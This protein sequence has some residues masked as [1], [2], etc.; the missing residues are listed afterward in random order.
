[1][2]SQYFPLDVPEPGLEMWATAYN[3]DQAYTTQSQPFQFGCHEEVGND[4]LFN[5]TPVLAPPAQWWYPE[6]GGA[7][8]DGVYSNSLCSHKPPANW[9][10]IVR[11]RL[12][13]RRRPYAFWVVLL[14]RLRLSVHRLAQ[15][16]SSR[17]RYDVHGNGGCHVYGRTIGGA[18]VKRDCDGSKRRNQLGRQRSIRAIYRVFSKWTSAIPKP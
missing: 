2:A 11:H 4:D 15:Y 1:M 18:A 10:D 3:S 12:S 13:R 5:F 7:G 9:T 8:W 14:Y 6:D 16:D 17:V